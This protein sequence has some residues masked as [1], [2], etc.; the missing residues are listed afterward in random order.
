[1]LWVLRVIGLPVETSHRSVTHWYTLLLIVVVFTGF[2][3]FVVHGSRVLRVLCKSMPLN[4]F[5]LHESRLRLHLLHIGLHHRH[6]LG[7]IDLRTHGAHH[8]LRPLGVLFEYLGEL[9][10]R[11]GPQLPEDGF[12]LF[13]L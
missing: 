5:L 6:K 2:H 1:M 4:L 9:I 7:V 10:L 11:L 3:H 8:L 12:G 13:F